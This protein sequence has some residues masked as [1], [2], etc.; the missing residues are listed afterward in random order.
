[1]P[2]TKSQK[3]R[4]AL[5]PKEVSYAMKRIPPSEVMKQEADAILEGYLEEGSPLEALARL[6]SP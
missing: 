4:V 6:D 5:G 3:A 2:P 1:M